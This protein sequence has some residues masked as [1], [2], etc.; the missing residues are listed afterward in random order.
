MKLKMGFIFLLIFLFIIFL[1]YNLVLNSTLLAFDLWLNKVFPFLF[2]MIVLNDILINLNFD[3]IF[4]S[5][6]PFIFFMSLISGAPSNAYIISK[7]YKSQKIN[8]TSANYSLLFTYFANP[9]FL[10]AILS[11]M[12]NHFIALKLIF[13][14]YISNVIIYL[15]WRKKIQNTKINNENK[16]HLNLGLS[17]NKGLQTLTM[18]LGTITFFM[19]ITNLL[20]KCLH[21]N[22]FL[23]LIS[24]GFL[25][26]TQGLNY[27]IKYPIINKLKQVIAISFISFGGLSI[28]TQIKCLLEESDLEYK[29]FFHGRI[30]QMLIAA[31]LTA[32]T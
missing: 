5:S 8:K 22:N 16:P 18:I 7:L 10:Y 4:K 9:L 20:T 25:E 13:I 26:V 19:V 2:I 11:T 27:L 17:I 29:Y 1:N 24:K 12:F 32:L 23:T 21:F 30:Y 31:I 14:H 3:K 28:H 6:T 15:I